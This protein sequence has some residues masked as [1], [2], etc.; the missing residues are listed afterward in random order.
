MDYE[1]SNIEKKEGVYATEHLDRQTVAWA[2]R[3]LT[4]PRSLVSYLRTKNRLL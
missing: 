3:Q 1:V 2:P 4:E